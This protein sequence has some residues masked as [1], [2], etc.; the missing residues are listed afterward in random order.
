MQ[1]A[2]PS[3]GGAALVMSP[4]VALRAVLDDAEREPGAPALVLA[5]GARCGG[6]FAAFMS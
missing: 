3:V 1:N 6:G 2:R 5:T 4:A